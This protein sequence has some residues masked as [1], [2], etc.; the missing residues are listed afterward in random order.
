MRSRFHSSLAATT[1]ARI[2]L[3]T[4]DIV[5][6]VPGSDCLREGRHEASRP[7]HS[8][9]AVHAAAAATTAAHCEQQEAQSSIKQ[10]G[11]WYFVGQMQLALPVSKYGTWACNCAAQKDRRMKSRCSCN[12]EHAVLTVL[13]S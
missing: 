2:T 1:N 11:N 12:M 9:P 10:V 13:C 5:R 6:M 7:T 3:P 8:S 4:H